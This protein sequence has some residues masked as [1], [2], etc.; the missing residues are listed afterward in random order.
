M[1]GALI[2]PA[3]SLVPG[4]PMF[5]VPEEPA[6]AAMMILAAVKVPPSA[7][8]RLW[9]LPPK[10]TKSSLLLVHLESAPVTSTLLLEEG[11]AKPITPIVLAIMPPLLMTRLLPLPVLPTKR[12][13]VLTV[14][15]ELLPVTT[16]LLLEEAASKPI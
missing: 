3:V 1:V 11:A 6:S 12:S 16:T 8:V 14:Q 10:P 4:R 2:V 15:S 5:S 13:D 7:M 9:P